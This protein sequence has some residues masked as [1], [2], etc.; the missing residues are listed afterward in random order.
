M[1]D[2]ITGKF[3]SVKQLEDAYKKLEVE[4]TKRCQ[5]VAQLEKEL[6][7]LKNKQLEKEQI[8]TL[9]ANEDFINDYI[10]SSEIISNAVVSKY[11]ST[12]KSRNKINLLGSSGTV[13]LYV[14]KKP[15]NLIE[16]KILADAIIKQS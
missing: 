4:F 12:L 2:K 3:D 7:E 10:L 16:A 6:L 1:K 15:T 11:L 5:K 14:D 9:L 8:I 13:A